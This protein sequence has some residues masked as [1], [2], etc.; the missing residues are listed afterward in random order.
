[1]SV[2]S[3]CH[4]IYLDRERRYKLHDRVS[5]ETVG[6]NYPVW[7]KNLTMSS[8]K[9]EIFCKYLLTN[10]GEGISANLQGNRY[11]INLPD[12]KLCTE[13]F[14]DIPLDPI[15]S[16]KLLDPKDDGVGALNFQYNDQSTVNE[17][18]YKIVHFVDIK[19]YSYFYD[20][21]LVLQKLGWTIS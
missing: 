3:I 18:P 9:Q 10:S 11:I 5:V 4:T 16:K 14:G 19:D 15:N 6:Y 17:K 21:S 8:P 12:E 2:L 7:M 1:M 13:F 20:S